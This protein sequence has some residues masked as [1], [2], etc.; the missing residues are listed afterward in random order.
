MAKAI[1]QLDAAQR[2]GRPWRRIARAPEAVAGRPVGRPLPGSAEL[3]RAARCAL[4][5]RRGR[6][7]AMSR[8]HFDHAP[9]PACGRRW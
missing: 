4:R 6:A 9:P 7:G 1:V 5:R 3:P 2:N 8:G